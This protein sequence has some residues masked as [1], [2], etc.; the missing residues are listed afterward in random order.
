MYKVRRK[1]L[2]YNFHET[3]QWKD[4]YMFSYITDLSCPPCGR[5]SDSGHL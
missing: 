2:L 5:A 1:T 4:F 3:D